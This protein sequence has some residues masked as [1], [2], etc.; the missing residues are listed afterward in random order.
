[1]IS[2]ANPLKLG[3]IYNNLPWPHKA[4]YTVKNSGSLPLTVSSVT[5]TS[6]GLEIS[7]LPA[8]INSLE[9]AELSLSLDASSLPEGPYSGS[10]SLASDDPLT[11]EYTVNVTGDVTAA[12]ITNYIEENFNGTDPKGWGTVACTKIQEGGVNNSGCI[13]ALLHQNQPQGGVQTC[14]VQMGS[15]PSVSLRYKVIDYASNQ[16]AAAGAMDYAIYVSKDGGANFDE[17]TSG[18]TVQTNDY[19]DIKAD[20]KAYAGELCLVQIVFEPAAGGENWLY[21]DDITV[22]SKPANEMSAVTISGD[23][24][25]EAGKATD[26]TVT[27][28][29]NGSKAQSNYEVALMSAD[30]T[31]IS[32]TKGTSIAPG[33][34]RS[35]NLAWTPAEGGSQSVYGKVILASDEYAVNDV[36]QPYNVYVRDN[37]VA[38]VQIGDGDKKIKYPYNLSIR[39]SL[40]QTIY[41]ANELGTNGGNIHALRYN[42]DITTEGP[43][44][45]DVGIE[46]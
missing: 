10:F 2:G 18:K 43:N 21:I 4:T 44:L 6:D 19:V 31:L 13:R 34:Q 3:S 40:T 20:A 29:N 35:F 41:L 5:S 8:V 30:N 32:S 17:L 33:E 45:Q 14:Y 9:T 15:N 7:G 1:M 23:R 36:T 12:V 16:P 37:S 46:I 28:Q 25:P 39:E 26:Y 24:I 11:P 22:G 42:A 38:T 27:V